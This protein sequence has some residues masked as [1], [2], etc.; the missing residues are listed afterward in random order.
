MVHGLREVVILP[1]DLL[2]QIE[3]QYHDFTQPVDWMLEVGDKRLS[4]SWTLDAL[5]HVQDGRLRMAD[6]AAGWTLDGRLSGDQ[7]YLPHIA[8]GLQLLLRS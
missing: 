5:G 6:D 3:R 4:M 8:M 1:L 2:T 7:S